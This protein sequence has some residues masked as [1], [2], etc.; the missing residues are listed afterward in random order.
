[1]RHRG[2]V[3]RSPWLKPR[4]T[5]PLAGRAITR[6]HWRYGYDR[7]GGPRARAV[8]CAADRCVD[9]SV[10]R[11]QSTA[12]SGLPIATPFRLTL[13]TPGHKRIAPPLRS[14]HIR[15]MVDFE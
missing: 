15:L 1:M 6:V 9:A 5:T 3:Y 10:N 13:K 7:P 2:Q 4:P 8:L 12:F 11:S 14:G